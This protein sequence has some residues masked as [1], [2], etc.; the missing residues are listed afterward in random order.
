M[1]V[2]LIFYVKPVEKYLALEP[3]TG[4]RKAHYAEMQKWKILT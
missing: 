1:E 3:R 2:S 4:T